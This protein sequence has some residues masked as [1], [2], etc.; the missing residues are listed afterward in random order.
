MSR[1][2]L[3]TLATAATIAAAATL[4]SS[5]ADARGF[6]AGGG[7]GGGGH[8]GGGG[9][10]RMGGGGFGGHFNGGHFGGRNFSRVGHP[11]FGHPGNWGH[12]NHYNHWNHWAHWH[13]RRWFW[14][15]GRWVIIDGDEGGYPVAGPVASPAP[16]PC[17]CLT[18]TYTQDG[19][20]VFADVCTK[21]AAS[22]RVDGADATP[23]APP[24][25]SSELTPP[26]PPPNAAVDSK[27]DVSQA[28]TT[29][30]YAGKTFQDFLAANAVATQKN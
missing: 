19:L 6:G 5:A 23:P 11:G 1:K 13:H 30:N 27:P 28:P 24:L 12:Y 14:R 15:D 7:F 18:K 22:A 2:I 10:S 16:G 29:N 4:A 21:E 8:F 25:K 20:V 3:F 17:T 9:F 26:P